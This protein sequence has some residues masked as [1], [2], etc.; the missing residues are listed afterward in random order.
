MAVMAPMLAPS[1]P[2]PTQ[3]N[4]GLLTAKNDQKSL[5]E[6]DQYRYVEAPKCFY[7]DKPQRAMEHDDVKALV[8][9]K[10]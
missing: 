4:I 5:V 2:S 3:P 1:L 10:L 8:E 7:I 6:L 9:W